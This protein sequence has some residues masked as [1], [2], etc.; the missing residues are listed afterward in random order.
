MAAECVTAEQT[1]IYSEDERADADAESAVEPERFPEVVGKNDGK[2]E[3]DVHEVAVNVLHDERE[4]T[5]TEISFAR[6]ADGARGRV[7]PK[8]FV[9]RAA[10][11]ITGHPK[12]A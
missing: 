10:I 6:L 2:E 9:I 3:R 12:S 1:N 5:L 8:R 11:I 4:R 7:G